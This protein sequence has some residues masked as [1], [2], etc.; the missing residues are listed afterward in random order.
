ML[1]A[2]G[3]DGFGWELLRA[4]TSRRIAPDLLVRSS[5]ISTF[6]YTKLINQE[7]GEEDQSRV[8]FI[9]PYTIPNESRTGDCIAACATGFDGFDVILVCDQAETECGGIVTPAVRELLIEL[10]NRES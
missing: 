6:T 9:Y 1:G 8:D 4:L 7:T 3:D 5:A 2:V 10:D